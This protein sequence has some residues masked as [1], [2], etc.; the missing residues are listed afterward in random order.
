MFKSALF[1]SPRVGGESKITMAY[2]VFSCLT[3]FLQSRGR[4]HIAL[5]YSAPSSGLVTEFGRVTSGGKMY[6]RHSH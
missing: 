3:S 6:G 4:Y 5:P 2:V 1:Y